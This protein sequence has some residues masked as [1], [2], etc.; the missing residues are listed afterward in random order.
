MELVKLYFWLYCKRGNTGN[1]ARENNE[2]S[3][4]KDR[5]I[6]TRYLTFYLNKPAVKFTRFLRV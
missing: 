3:G 4:C 2:K 1:E 6:V 5:L